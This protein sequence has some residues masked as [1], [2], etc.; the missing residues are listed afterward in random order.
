MEPCTFFADSL[1][2]PASPIEGWPTAPDIA[3]GEV[4]G[5]RVRPR[6]PREKKLVFGLSKIFGIDTAKKAR[7]SQSSNQIRPARHSPEAKPMAGG[8]LERIGIDAQFFGS[9]QKGLG[10]YVQKLVEGLEKN[11]RYQIPDTRY[12][13]IVFLRRENWHDYQPQN[14]LFK[15]VLADYKWYGFKEQIFMPF[16]IRQEKIDLMH[17]PHFNLPILCPTP[18]VVTIHDLVLKKFPTRRA[19]TFGLILYRL[20]NLAY[21]LVIWLAVKRA[22]KIIAVSSYTK[23]DILRYFKVR[24]EKIEV[25]YEGAPQPG[26]GAAPHGGQ[27]PSLAAAVP[28]PQKPYVLYVGNAYPHKNL[29]RLILAFAKI[30]NQEYQLVLVGEIDYFY[31][32]L[33][34]FVHNSKFIIH[35]SVVFI[36]LVSDKQLETL[37]QNASLYVFPSLYEGFG[38]PALEAMAF[39]LP[40]VSS[41]A[42]SLPEI[43]GRAAFYFDPDD[44]DGMAQAIKRGLRD[45][46]LREKLREAG[47]EQIKKYSWSK[48]A[49]E[50]L[51]IYQKSF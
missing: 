2:R 15:K 32:K 50:T 11:T 44:I 38:L 25:V 26:W 42:A 37:Y 5:G 33:K 13:F 36:G 10:R 40:I 29:E 23:Q 7:G 39:G 30:K 6:R 46:D 12:N 16:K 4:K 18:F 8:D 9:R 41:K 51:E 19:S 14:H 1:G 22:K 34:E 43:L 49:Q 27:P 48:M 17:F 20:K 47:F 21:Q 31:N 35:D 28:V 3:F 24:P 45:K